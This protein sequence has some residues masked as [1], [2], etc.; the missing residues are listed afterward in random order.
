M[1]KTTWKRKFLP[2]L[3]A[4]LTTL[5]FAAAAL[6]AYAVTGTM[7]VGGTT[8]PDLS[9]DGNNTG[10][11]WTAS[12]ATLALNNSYANAN[13]IDIQCEAEDIINLTYTGDV[14]VSPASGAALAC[15][16]SLNITGSGGTLTL[17]GGSGDSNYYAI[18]TKG[19]LEI[20]SGTVAATAADAMAIYT[21]WTGDVTISGNA[22][23][24]VN[25]VAGIVAGNVT[26][27]TSGTVNASATGE[28]SAA[29]N[30]DGDITI[31][32]GT[33]TATTTAP[34]NYTLMGNTYISG[35]TVSLSNTGGGSTIS[36]LVS[37][38]GG[39]VTY[40]SGP[41][42]T[43]T[44][45][46][47]NTGSTRGGTLN[48]GLVGTNL[49][50]LTSVKI[51][52]TGIPVGIGG[53]ISNLT[54]NGFM[55][56]IPIVSSSTYNPGTPVYVVVQTSG[57]AAY[58]QNAFTFID[59]PN[60][61]SA[62]TSA[63]GSKVLVTFDADMDGSTL[64]PDDFIVQSGGS[65][66]AVTAASL[67]SVNGGIVELTLAAPVANGQN[68]TVAHN[69]GSAFLVQARAASGD[70]LDDFAA[71]PVTN[72]VAPDETYGSGGG[73]GGGGTPSNETTPAEIS[74][75][76]SGAKIKAE[77]QTDGTWLIVLPAGSDAA[78]LKLSFTLPSGATI[79]PANGSA[80]DFSNGP[81][82][83]TVTAADKTTKTAIVVAVKVESA[84]PTERQYF[85]AA[86]GLCEVGY[87]TNAGSATVNL[88]IPLASG[89]DP[90]EI[91]AIRATLTGVTPLGTL[92]YAY[93]DAGGNLVPI[94][95]KSARSASVPVPYLQ[96]TFEAASLDA[97]KAGG[98]EKIAYWLK[99]DAT[100]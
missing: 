62:A 97:A 60:F 53:N 47:P 66:N 84:A 40:G 5:L 52:V 82:T 29:I 100:E 38:T 99:G 7:T 18:S 14:T 54:S 71:K 73:S 57:G 88:R 28:Y 26:L 9:A 11:T 61:V 8:V 4:L 76:L 31:S 65:A 80:Q 79:S 17:T 94:T 56:L 51:G 49:S 44:S 25:G 1:I 39:T 19:N 78:A 13:L 15:E 35:G 41:A 2:A 92:S 32:G 3:S 67:N 93:A 45:L 72:T 46:S 21:N 58:L 69:A 98:L 50:D 87:V 48:V 77:K 23:V 68:V 81:V 70:Y 10:W 20:S 91:E 22:S 34:S 16:G 37:L 42:P 27:S 74:V 36:N 43:I 83:Y 33:V 75:T 12:T 96:I 63:D 89:A 64:V 95:T 90:E 24:T 59:T 55:F 85:S 6:P 30:S 86:P